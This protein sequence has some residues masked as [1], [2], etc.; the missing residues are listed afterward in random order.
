MIKNCLIS[1]LLY[2]KYD[3]SD[4]RVDHETSRTTWQVSYVVL[5]RAIAN[6]S[7]LYNLC[8][9]SLHATIK[10]SWVYY[11]ALFSLRK[12]FQEKLDLNMR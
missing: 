11:R 7:V 4:N 8:V 12:S 9:L 1:L 2:Y 10:S 6:A 3:E 5:G